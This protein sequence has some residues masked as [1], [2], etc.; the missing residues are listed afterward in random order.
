MVT[1]TQSLSNSLQSQESRRDPFQMD[2]TFE[3]S[4]LPGRSSNIK[5]IAEIEGHISK[6]NFEHAVSKLANK[7]PLLRSKVV[8]RE[9]GSA[10]FSTE[11]APKPKIIFLDS[12]TDI[13]QAIAEQDK[14]P[15][16]WETDPTSRFMLRSNADNSSTIISYIHHT[17]ADGRAVAYLMKHL[18]EF[19]ADPHKPVN[20]LTPISLLDVIPD[21]VKIGKLIKKIT[22]MVNK[23]WDKEKVTFTMEDYIRV[24]EQKYHQSADHYFGLTLN[25]DQTTKLRN[26]AR[27]HGVSVNSVILAAC[28]IANATE[29]TSPLP[30]KV[31]FAVDVRSKLTQN[32]G[33]ACNLL[34]SGAI[35]N[36][37]YKAGMTIWEIAQN[38]HRDTLRTIGSNK[39]LFL[40]R[41]MAPLMDPTFYDAIYMKQQG[42]WEGTPML[43]KMTSKK[44]PVGIVLTNLGGMH[45]PLA[46]SGENTLILR[47]MNFFP[48]IGEEGVL[49]FGASSL[50][51][52]LHFVTVSKEDAANREIKVRIIRKVIDILKTID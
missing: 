35:A 29:N 33:E 20:E 49:E 16:N 23:K 4:F 27:N 24:A 39:K 14:N 17:I 10:Y 52:K 19:I 45:L 21:T 34:A 50:A 48:P 28:I 6:K 12:Q 11:N 46:Y 30:K 43:K 31:G 9:D 44:S 2:L 22:G 25:R 41:L 8:V 36:P 26:L 32:P 47:D 3:R 38:I 7:H 37:K 18:L 1:Q 5:I 15:A 42:G 51:G 13:F 40:R